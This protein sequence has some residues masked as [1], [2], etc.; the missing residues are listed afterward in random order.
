MKNKNCL[1]ST[2]VFSVSVGKPH[3]L[4]ATNRRLV[5]VSRIQERVKKVW[6]LLEYDEMSMKRGEEC[7]TRDA[8]NK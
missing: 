4:G 1:Q 6:Y 2:I 7:C 5:G 3:L 8:S